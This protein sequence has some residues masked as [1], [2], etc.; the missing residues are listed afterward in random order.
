MG[1]IVVSSIVVVAVVIVFL[2]VWIHV[3]DAKKWCYAP[4]KKPESQ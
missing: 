4:S 3:E 1:W 2:L